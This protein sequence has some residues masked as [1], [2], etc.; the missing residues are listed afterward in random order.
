MGRCSF[1]AKKTPGIREWQ[2][3]LVLDDQADINLLER[4]DA[5][6]SGQWGV[7]EIYRPTFVPRSL[8]FVS[9]FFIG[10]CDGVSGTPKNSFSVAS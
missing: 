2:T 4:D 5:R 7:V 6:R 10:F 3:C 9:T 8:W 1:R